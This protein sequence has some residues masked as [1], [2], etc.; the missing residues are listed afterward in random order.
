MIEDQGEVV[1]RDEQGTEHVFPAGFDPQKAAAI[2]RGQQQPPQDAGI[3]AGIKRTLPTLSGLSQIPDQIRTSFAPRDDSATI[4]QIGDVSKPIPFRPSQSAVVQRPK[5][6]LGEAIGTIGQMGLASAI[7]FAARKL[8]APGETIQGVPVEE[9]RKAG[10]GEAAIQRTLRGDQ[11]NVVPFK[12]IAQPQPPPTSGNLALKPIQAPEAPPSQAA[13]PNLIG[14]QTRPMTELAPTSLKPTSPQELA[15]NMRALY[16]SEKAGR[17]LN[18]A[19]PRGGAEQIQRLAPGPSRQPLTQQL[20]ELDQRYQRL[21]ND[22]RGFI[23]P[24]LMRSMGLP[25]EVA[26]YPL[27]YR[28]MGP[29]GIAL[30]AGTD[31]ARLVKAY[32]V[33]SAE[34]ARELLLGNLA[35]TSQSNAPKP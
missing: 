26:K 28:T 18:P 11:S 27:A 17:M 30:A 19:D 21:I 6:A 32:P 34:I 29:G 16:G 33:G 4:A 5:E 12:P 2:V 8:T 14:Q 35:N 3:L 9:L 23:S 1:I 24:T 10:V 7:P 22:P 20:A 13:P 25:W 31:A 15:D